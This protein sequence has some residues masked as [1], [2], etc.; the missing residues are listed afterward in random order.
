MALMPYT[1]RV[2]TQRAARPSAAAQAV[3]AAEA[4]LAVDDEVIVLPDVEGEE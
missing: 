4:E 1:K 2:S 3:A